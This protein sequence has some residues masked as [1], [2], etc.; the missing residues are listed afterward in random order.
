[1][2][3][4]E[5]TGLV[6]AL[7]FHQPYGN[8][9]EV[10]ADAMERCYLPTLDLIAEH[11]QVRSAVHV[12]GPLLDWA[13]AHQPAMIERLASLVK[14]GQVEILGGGYQEPMLAILPDR[15]AIGQLTMMADRC[16]ELL[17]ARPEGMWLTER[18]WEP[19]LPRPIAEAGYRYTLLDDSHLH[20]AGA[21]EPLGAY[22]VT[23]KAGAKVA[24]FPIDRGLR[25]RIPYA[26]VDELIDYLRAQRGRVV[27]YGDDAEK[28]GVWPTTEKRVWTDRW[29]ARFFEALESEKD[30]LRTATPSEIMKTEPSS[31]AIYIPTISYQEMGAWTLPPE[32]STRFSDVA[33]RMNLAGY[34][35]EVQ[36]FLRGGIWQAFLAKYPE[37]NLI[38]RKMLR[39]SKE[40]AEAESADRSGW[41]QAKAALYQ[42][43]CNC[44]YWHG[45]FGGLY[46]Q[47]LRSALMSALLEA[48]R[49]AAPRRAV[50]VEQ[51]DYDGD[52]EDEIL[53]EG[54][55]LNLY[56]S[57]RRGGS[58]IELDLRGPRYHLT[59]VLGRRPEAYHS[60]VARAQVLSDEEL[61]NVSAHDLVRATEEGL[62]EKLV[63]DRYP[64][65]VFV[66]HLLPADADADAFDRRYE[67]LADFANARY[68][69][70]AVETE[71]G[72]AVAKL[73]CTQR[74]HRLTKEI[75]VDETGAEARYRLVGTRSGPLRFATQIDV[76]LLSPEQVGG[77]RIE[78]DAD[79]EVDPTPGAR[80]VVPK[81][82]A[83][84]VV[85]ED[86]GIDVMLRPSPPAELWRLP[87]ETVSQS[88]RGFES[89]YQGTALIFV[90]DG[91]ASDETPL[92]AQLTLE[93]GSA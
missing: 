13:E 10:F 37:S 15:D 38:Y 93:V 5:H 39:V 84:R 49:I 72:K 57:P 78:V 48:E 31:G 63:V 3:H 25:T 81:V 12:S 21:V 52:L 59:G 64:R 41:Q 20:A 71:G 43:Q 83:V 62:A 17:G 54:P 14:S 73:Q 87:I 11:P 70:E 45:L 88:E 32:A 92:E 28:F 8:L 91:E 80:A 60:D 66:D 50:T 42:G 29:L 82:R 77:R 69:V 35:Q 47:H 51:S 1:M 24:V 74:G 61:E 34:Q 65:G 2:A 56:V 68:E 55:A 90:W 4:P 44:A 79:Q 86:Q 30:W 22:Y 67:P 75:H 9:D 76:T 40:V 58:G 19:D 6:F 18:V 36:S 89:A 23:D 16:E 46:L 53:F 27:V 33:Q 85:S 26:E 7:H